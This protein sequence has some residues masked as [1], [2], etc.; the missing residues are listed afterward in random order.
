MR[1]SLATSPQAPTTAHSTFAPNPAER[2][3]MA[4]DHDLYAIPGVTNLGYYPAVGDKVVVTFRT[5]GL[6]Q[7][8]EMILEDAIDG[9]QLVTEVAD[10]A[11]GSPDPD[12]SLWKHQ[13]A[14]ASVA[15][16]PG[17]WDERTYS[18]PWTQDGEVT[19][20]AVN[21]RV[22]DHLDPIIRDQIEGQKRADG[23]LRQ[24]AVKWKVVDGAASS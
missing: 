13:Q 6:R 17:V 9:V 11:G 2:V 8:G 18:G 23:S 16:L 1:T 19:F 14:I 12:T 15:A 3:I 24:Y 5:E 20:F 7:I 4:Y 10:W 22:V 21:Q